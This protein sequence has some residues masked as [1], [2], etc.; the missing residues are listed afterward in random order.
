MKDSPLEAPV[1]AIDRRNFLKLGAGA[2][3][4]AVASLHAPAASAHNASSDP[5]SIDVHAHWVPE[6]Y[7]KALAEMGHPT[8]SIHSPLEVDLAKRIK[9]MDEHGIQM[10]VLTLDGGMPWQWIAPEKGARLAQLVNDAAIEAH[11]MY[12]G[13][14]IAGIEVSIR[15]AR[16]AL[17]EINRV[18]G[19]PGLRAVHLP[20]SIGD[21]DYLF[22]E[23]YESL[24]AR[25]EQLGYPLLFHP[26]DGEANFYGGNAR[27]GGQLELAANLNNSLGFTF[28]SAT[29]AAKFI[30]TGTL[31]KFPALEI[32]LPHSGGCFPYDAGRIERG[33]AAK[34]FKLQRP[35]REYIRRFHYDSLTYYPETLR[36]LVT[37]VGPDRVVIGTDVFAP[38]DVEDPN[39]F[40]EQIN[41]PARERDL[42]LRGNAVR[43]F[44]L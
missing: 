16:L 21:N 5:G 28:E 38:M 40:I 19:K 13:R 34:K 23:S 9:W 32:V 44:R 41:L 6:A 20:N 36:Y 26:L 24:F 31:D 12:P 11:Q 2:G 42:I 33:L 15:D 8:G 39:A 4:I 43:L 37:L 35:F 14:F 3:A 27:L 30:I 17:A 22:D 7:S 18:A 25:C 10:H 1:P 29:T